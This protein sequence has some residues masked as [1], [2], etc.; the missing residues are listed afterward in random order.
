MITR[1]PTGR[2]PILLAI[3]FLVA[4]IDILH[5]EENTLVVEV[6]G[7]SS[8]GKESTIAQVE[9]QAKQAAL[10]QA[11]EQAGV[12]LESTTEVNMAE[13]SKDE[14]QSWAQGF[15]KVLEVLANKTDF[16]PELKA[17]RCEMLLK[18]EVRTRD[19]S[20]LLERVKQDRAS[21]AAAEQ[22]LSFE[23]SFLAQRRME[24]G[25]WAEVRVKDGSVLRSGDQFQISVRADRDCRGYVINQDA[26]GKVYVLFPHEKARSNRLTGG[27]EYSLPDRDLFYELDDV[28]GLETFYLAASPTPMADLEWI[29]DQIEKLGEDASGMVAVLDGTLRK[30]GGRTRGTKVAAKKSKGMLSSGE[31]VEKV[32]EM[33]EGRGALVRVVTVDH[34]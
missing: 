2:L 15:V 18:V 30:R 17:F 21:Q 22:P 20:E 12:Y 4:S 31:T 34:R 16:D 26:S 32:T 11:V 7:E 33:I 1:V 6:S 3:L 25:E 27:R 19:M 29:I 24:G 14:I 5:S 23:Y 8:G 10:G 28:V 13:I 9:D